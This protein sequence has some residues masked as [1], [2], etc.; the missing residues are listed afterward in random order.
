MFLAMVFDIKFTFLK[1]FC[2][3][4]CSVHVTCL[5][6]S[7]V[8]LLIGCYLVPLRAYIKFISRPHLWI[9]IKQ[10]LI[11]WCKM[12]LENLTQLVLMSVFFFLC[13]VVVV[14][15]KFS[16]Y[17]SNYVLCFA[18]SFYLI[19]LCMRGCTYNLMHKFTCMFPLV[20][21]FLLDTYCGY[22]SAHA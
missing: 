19:A 15:V 8:A 20:C 1:V 7:Q 21:L 4:Y 11:C 13:G 22:S 9:C 12:G 18:L 16:V 6:E 10:N 5:W 2:F 14:V 3:S 17:K